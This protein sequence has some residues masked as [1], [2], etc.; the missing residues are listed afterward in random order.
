[1]G[2]MVQQLTNTCDAG[3]TLA[4]AYSRVDQ[5]SYKATFNNAATIGTPLLAQALETLRSSDALETMTV[6]PNRGLPA[7][8]HVPGARLKTTTARTGPL[9]HGRLTRNRR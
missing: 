4:K 7:T 2:I 1:M 9:P 6:R 8:R 5:T 3:L